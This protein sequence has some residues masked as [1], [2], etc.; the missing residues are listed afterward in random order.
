MQVIF[1][2]W[3]SLAVMVAGLLLLVMVLSGKGS[4]VLHHVVEAIRAYRQ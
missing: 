1:N 3:Q 2:D 4:D